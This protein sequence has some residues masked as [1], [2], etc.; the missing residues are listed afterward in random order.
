MTFVIWKKI[1]TC[2]CICKSTAKQNVIDRSAYTM[3]CG[4]ELG[5][6]AVKQLDLARCA[7][8]HIVNHATRVHFVLDTFE[9]ERMLTDLAQLHK[10]VGQAPHSC[11]FAEN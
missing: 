6:N 11:R 3:V 1:R 2:G 10:F 7:D 8:E 9:Q 4:E 5:E